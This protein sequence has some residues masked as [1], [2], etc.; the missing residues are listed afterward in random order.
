MKAVFIDGWKLEF[1]K[2]V[3]MYCHYLRISRPDLVIEPP[4]EDMAIYPKTM[5]IWLEDLGLKR[6]TLNELSW[7]L[8]KWAV[9]R[10]LG[11]GYIWTEIIL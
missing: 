11:V 6:P 3:H 5:G 4:C 9:L 2:N 1:R 10:D 8:Q 7:V